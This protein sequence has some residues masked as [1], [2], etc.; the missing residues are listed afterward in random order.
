MDKQTICTMY[1]VHK[2]GSSLKGSKSNLWCVLELQINIICK[3]LFSNET[4]FS[5]IQG[6]FYGVQVSSF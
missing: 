2:Q 5:F 6:L 4:L 3:N 1:F